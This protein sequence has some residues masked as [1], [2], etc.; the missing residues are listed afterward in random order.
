MRFFDTFLVDRLLILDH[1][2][3]ALSQAPSQSLFFIRD[4]VAKP[5]TW[6]RLFFARRNAAFGAVHS[7][8]VVAE[9][10]VVIGMSCAPVF[11]A[12]ERLLDLELAARE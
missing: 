2:F 3:A 1:V 5:W 11:L 10:R 8:I 9:L 12:D 7:F 4:R 6:M